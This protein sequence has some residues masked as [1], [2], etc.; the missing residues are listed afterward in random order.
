MEKECRTCSDYY[1]GCCYSKYLNDSLE[2]NTINVFRVSESGLLSDVVKE[3]VG[4]YLTKRKDDYRFDR[5]LRMNFKMSEKRI[6]EISGK[7]EDK[8]VSFVKEITSDLMDEISSLY[9][10]YED[11]CLKELKPLVYEDGGHAVSENFCCKY[12][13]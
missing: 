6:S 8:L 1:N 11:G 13:R 7:A 10:R 5:Y 2:E 12:W 9:E 3:F 4:D